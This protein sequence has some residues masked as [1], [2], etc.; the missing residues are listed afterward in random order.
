MS[1][2][3]RMVCTC[4]I[5]YNN[6]CTEKA[7]VFTETDWCISHIL[8]IFQFFSFIV[9]NPYLAAVSRNSKCFSV[10][11]I[12]CRFKHRLDDCFPFVI[13]KSYSVICTYHCQTF[14]KITAAVILRFY[15]K[16]SVFI[17]KSPM[18]ISCF[19]YRYCS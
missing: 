14:T 2:N 1:H 19:S 16:V 8:N 17:Y 5:F 3:M 4:Q 18:F 9:N 10:S 6:L 11:K 15:N 12:S 7:T 13:N